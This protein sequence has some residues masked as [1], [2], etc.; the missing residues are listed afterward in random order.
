MAAI[1]RSFQCNKPKISNKSNSSKSKL[2]KLQPR[3]QQLLRV[4][5]PRSRSE[6]VLRRTSGK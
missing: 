4:A 5:S 2:S 6:D 3:I 1:S